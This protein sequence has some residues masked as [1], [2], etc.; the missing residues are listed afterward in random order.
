MC[1][2]FSLTSCLYRAILSLKNTPTKGSAMK[3]A[4]IFLAFI[5]V[6]ILCMMLFFSC[7]DNSKANTEE[8]D[9]VYTYEQISQSEAKAL[10]DSEKVSLK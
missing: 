9:T 1:N 4:P 6:L 7:S 3:N 2:S 5:P 10:M 8:T